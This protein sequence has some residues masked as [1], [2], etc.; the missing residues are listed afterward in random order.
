MEL[1]PSTDRSSIAWMVWRAFPSRRLFTRRKALR[2]ADFL[3]SRMSAAPALRASWGRR[4]WV[5]V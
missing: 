2:C 1:Y 4:S 3:P 5:I